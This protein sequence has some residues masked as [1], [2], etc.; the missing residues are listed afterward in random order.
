MFVY[1]K[2]TANV[3]PI[4]EGGISLTTFNYHIMDLVDFRTCIK[5][6]FKSRT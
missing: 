5:P 2:I 3:I 1:K 6:T 4:L